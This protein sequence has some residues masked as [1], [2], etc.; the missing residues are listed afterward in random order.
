MKNFKLLIAAGLAALL[1]LAHAAEDTNGSTEGGSTTSK[2]CTSEHSRAL[3]IARAA[4]V[5]GAMRDMTESDTKPNMG[6]RTGDALWYA[7]AAV[8]SGTNLFRQA[9]GF[10]RGAEVG[11][12]AVNALAALVSG[13]DMLGRNLVVGWMPADMA[14]NKDKANAKAAAILLEATLAS[15]EGATVKPEPMAGNAEV[16]RYRITGGV[17]EGHECV[18][19]PALKGGD[20]GPVLGARS[21]KTKAPEFLGG[22]ESYRFGTRLGALYPL[23]LTVDGKVQT[24]TYLQKLSTHLPDWMYVASSPEA[25]GPNGSL[26]NEGQAVPVMYHKGEA[27][28]F[29]FP[30][31]KPMGEALAAA[32]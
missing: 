27:M 23:V 28:F 10:S 14:A 31:V 3:C 21:F 15:F 4:H 25:K 5:A 20:T 11:L 9:K 19:T 6:R 18:L 30:E 13:S 1:G 8:G 12:F 26:V 24:H 22:G 32:R 16:T 2:T 29:A 17:C 7:G